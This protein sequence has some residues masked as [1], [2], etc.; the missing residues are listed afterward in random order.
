MGGGGGSF[1]IVVQYPPRTMAGMLTLAWAVDQSRR[2]FRRNRRR[3]HPESDTA[4]RESE[5]SMWSP[6]GSSASEGS[7]M[8]GYG[9]GTSQRRRRNPSSR[10][11][12]QGNPKQPDVESCGCLG[13]LLQLMGFGA[14]GGKL[15][16]AAAATAAGVSRGAPW[17]AAS[18]GAPSMVVSRGGVSTVRTRKAAHHKSPHSSH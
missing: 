14:G 18:R 12:Q 7:D 11:Q 16:A 17:T 8:D 1:A 15:K 5:S 6:R 13:I 4:S 2:V 10:Q 3:V 9:G